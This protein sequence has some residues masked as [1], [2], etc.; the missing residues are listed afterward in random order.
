MARPSDDHDTL[1]AMNVARTN[2][3]DETSFTSVHFRQN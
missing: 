2:F 1:R 3:I